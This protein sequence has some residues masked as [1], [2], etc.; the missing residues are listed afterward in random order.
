VGAEPVRKDLQQVPFLSSCTICKVVEDLKCEDPG[1]LGFFWRW[2]R[3]EKSPTPISLPLF[4][5]TK[6]LLAVRERRG[7]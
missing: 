1:S 6:G 4:L 5:Q 3:I 7:C 2:R